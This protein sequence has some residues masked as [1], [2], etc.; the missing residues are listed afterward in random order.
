MEQGRCISCFGRKF[1]E[2]SKS[3]LTD[4]FQ[5]YILDSVVT[6]TKKFCRK[7]AKSMFMI[8]YAATMTLMTAP[9][10]FVRLR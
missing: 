3:P 1:P 6:I 5:G 7:E 9:S 2:L 4:G 8:N 10:A